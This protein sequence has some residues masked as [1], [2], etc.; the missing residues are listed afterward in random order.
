MLLLVWLW[1]GSQACLTWPILSNEL[2]AKP[3][4]GNCN[5]PSLASH[6]LAEL[7]SFSFSSSP[8]SHFYSTN[9]SYCSTNCLSKKFESWNIRA[10]YMLGQ[11]VYV[12]M[13][14]TCPMVKQG[15]IMG[16]LDHLV[17]CNLWSTKTTL[18]F[19]LL[20][21]SSSLCIVIL[22]LQLKSWIIFS[23]LWERTWWPIF[24][25]HLYFTNSCWYA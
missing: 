16:Q 11:K 23:P 9:F 17:L 1:R 20:F 12:G 4:L 25:H 13:L 7:M 10:L 8:G 24:F 5:E 6:E 14:W 22:D 15:A 3:R 18:V 21:C 19:Y 2:K